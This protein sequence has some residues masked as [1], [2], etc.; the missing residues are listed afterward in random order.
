MSEDNNNCCWQGYDDIMAIAANG[1]D[2]RGWMDEPPPEIHDGKVHFKGRGNVIALPKRE[3][4][5]HLPEIQW[6]DEKLSDW[7]ERE[8]PDRRWLVPE[9]IPREQVTGLYGVGGINKTDFLVQLHLAKSAGLPF[10]GFKL[11][12]GPT[13]GLFCEDTSEEIVRRAARIS[14]HYGKSLADFPDFHFASLVGLD[15]P[16][17][18][19]FEGT[20]MKVTEALL[21]FDRKI[22]TLGAVLATLDTAPHFFGGNEVVRREVTKFLRKLDAIS[23]ARGC[24]MLYTAHPSVRGKSSK[25]FDSGS[26]GW[27]G[28]ARARIS[29]HDPGTQEDDEGSAGPRPA[30]DRRI[31]T[32]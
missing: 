21:R 15:D 1:G 31:L 14:A 25:T 28:S 2:P 27:E 13:Y 8:I 29:I 11:E 20:Q 9:W 5:H 24:G 23:I 18:V 3:R 22:T 4:E 32:R 12:P 7:A 19:I 6:H 16:E 10:L 17:F 26:T 30:T